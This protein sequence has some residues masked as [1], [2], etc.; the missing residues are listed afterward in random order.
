MAPALDT[1]TMHDHRE[2]FRHGADTGVRGRGATRAATF[3]PA[4]L[5]RKVARLGPLVCL[6]G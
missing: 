2:H 4:G 3:E 1:S 6:K 5:A